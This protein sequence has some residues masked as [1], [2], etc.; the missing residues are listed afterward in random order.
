MSPVDWATVYALSIYG[1]EYFNNVMA[2]A[3]VM[4][5]A[6]QFLFLKVYSMEKME[7]QLKGGGPTPTVVEQMAELS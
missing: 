6:E 3:M 1:T 2:L 7:M 4:A 5:M